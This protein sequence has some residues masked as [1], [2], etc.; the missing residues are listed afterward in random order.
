MKTA[1]TNQPYFFKRQLI[2]CIITFLFVFLSFV[3][4]SHLIIL[5]LSIFSV[6]VGLTFIPSIRK[7][8]KY[9]LWLHTLVFYF[10]LY[11][12][13]LVFGT[14][15]YVQNSLVSVFMGFAIGTAFLLSKKFELKD[16]LKGS[17]LHLYTKISL[18]QFALILFTQIV[19]IIS[20]EL[21][22]RNF[23][24]EIMGSIIGIWSVL[25][26]ALFFTL[27]HWLNRWSDKMFSL[28]SYCY[29]FLIGL[30]LGI[31]YYY[32]RSLLGCFFAHLIFN[33]PYLITSYKRIFKVE[34]SISFDDY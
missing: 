4:W 24:I 8:I 30:S 16:S 20:E 11:L 21:F 22:F 25:I 14:V 28:R 10:P 2:A 5:S 6:I 1:S 19:S 33:L 13:P 15:V 3:L 23:L 18:A 17:K 29:H 34:V 31:Y 32:T 9:P 12:F 7:I 26:S 27:I